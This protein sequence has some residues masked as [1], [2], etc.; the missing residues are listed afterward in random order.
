MREEIGSSNDRSP[1]RNGSRKTLSTLK[2]NKQT[3]MI[4]DQRLNSIHV[5][6]TPGGRE[7]TRNDETDPME[8]DAMSNVKLIIFSVIPM[9]YL[10][11]T[12]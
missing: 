9:F 3:G 1:D 5:E 8:V 7:S 12:L 11:A 6:S 4:S 10:T 2:L